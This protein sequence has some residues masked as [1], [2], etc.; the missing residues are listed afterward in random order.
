MIMKTIIETNNARSMPAREHSA[1]PRK[2]PGADLRKDYKLTLQTGLITSLLVV[3][4]LFHMSFESSGGLEIVMQEQEAVELEE[5]QQTQQQDM[6]PPPPRP[7]VPIE[8]PNESILEEDFLSLDATLDLNEPA[9]PIP[10][11]PPP[12]REEPREEAPEPEIFVVVEQMPEMIGGTARLMELVKYPELARQAGL[13]GLVVVQVVVEPDGSVS[14]PVII[15]SAGELLDRAA[16]AAV[17][18]TRFKPGMQRGQ[19]V[20]VSYAVPVRFRLRDASR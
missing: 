18:Q 1:V 9:A 5:I 2:A 8:V 12:P 11:P 19:P 3:T 16:I 13:E 20:R 7:P 14:N 4:G 15:R 17:I 10:A 6:P